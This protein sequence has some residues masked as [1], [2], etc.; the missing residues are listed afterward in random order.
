M[1][2]LP[3]KTI[4]QTDYLLLDVSNVAASVAILVDLS[5]LYLITLIASP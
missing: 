3:V 2:V 1:A 5:Y 4:R